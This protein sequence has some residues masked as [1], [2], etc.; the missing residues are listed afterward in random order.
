MQLALDKYEKN[1]F[2]AKFESDKEMHNLNQIVENGK[3]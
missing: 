3:L 2:Q 1:L